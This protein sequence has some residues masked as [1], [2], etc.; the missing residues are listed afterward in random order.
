MTKFRQLFK[1]L[2]FFSEKNPASLY[3]ILYLNIHSGYTF[4]IL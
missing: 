4:H 1:G 3:G 2:S